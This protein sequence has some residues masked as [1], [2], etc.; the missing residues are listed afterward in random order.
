MKTMRPWIKYF[1]ACG[2]TIVVFAAVVAAW[3]AKPAGQPEW[4]MLMHR[5]GVTELGRYQTIK[6]CREAKVE[7]ETVQ[8]KKDPRRQWEL[9]P[10]A[11]PFSYVPAV[12]RTHF[13]E[14]Q[15]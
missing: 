11:P 6:E 2:L 10:L 14:R 5:D 9:A 8:F 13:C 4:W 1:V 15:D 12:I 7:Y 3:T